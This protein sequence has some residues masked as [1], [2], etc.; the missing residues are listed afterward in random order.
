MKPEDQIARIDKT[1]KKIIRNQVLIFIL[2]FVL[3][4]VSVLS[5]KQISKA[6]EFLYFPPQIAR[7]PAGRFYTTINEEQLLGGAYLEPG[8]HVFRWPTSALRQD[9]SGVLGKI[10]GKYDFLQC[11]DELKYNVPEGSSYSKYIEYFKENDLWFDSF[12][13]G[14]RYGINIKEP[15]YFKPR[16]LYPECL[17]LNSS[18]YSAFDS[19][20]GDKKYDFRADFDKDKRV[21]IYDLIMLRE[22]FTDQEWC[23]RHLESSDPCE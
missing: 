7:E 3:I 20:C 6:T 11:Y 23:R 17:E 2:L 5:Y 10:E 13:P 8:W 21:W 9:V 14:K 19:G 12:E 1:Q 22:H 18:L 15:I 4:L 16:V